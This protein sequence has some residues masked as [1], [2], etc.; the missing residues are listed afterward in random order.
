MAKMNAKISEIA[1]MQRSS[2]I[3]LVWHG[4]T[5]WSQLINEIHYAL[6]K[7]T[8][9]FREK[10][11]DQIGLWGSRGGAGARYWEKS[12]PPGGP[13]YRQTGNYFNSILID[14]HTDPLQNIYT[15]QI[16]TDVPYAPALELG[17]LAKTIHPSLKKYTSIVLLKSPFKVGRIYRIRARPAWRPVFNKEW[18]NML[19]YFKDIRI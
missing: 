3:T 9:Y 6:L 10:L 17:G 11:Q 4:N 12:S 14:I 8:K 13:P 2:K 7:S 5:F 19:R 18:R 1:A 16:Y 15:A